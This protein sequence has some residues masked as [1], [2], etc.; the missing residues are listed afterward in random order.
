VLV[1]QGIT[2]K[3]EVGAPS[4]PP[5]PSPPLPSFNPVPLLF[6]GVLPQTALLTPH[7]SPHA[8]LIA[9]TSLQQSGA[10]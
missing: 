8:P 3:L 9:A 7:P 10:S 6:L 1:Q 4:A 2:A 5:L